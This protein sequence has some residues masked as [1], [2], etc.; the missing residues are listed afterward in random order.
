MLN[1]YPG[2]H[3]MNQTELQANVKRRNDRLVAITAKVKA[4]K[5]KVVREGDNLDGKMT[6]LENLEQNNN[7]RTQPILNP[8]P[9][10]VANVSFL[11]KIG[12]IFTSES[13]AA[14]TNLVS[15]DEKDYNAFIE[16]SKALQDILTNLSIK[17]DAIQGDDQN[18]KSETLL[19][20]VDANVDLSSA[21]LEELNPP[22]RKEYEAEILKVN[23]LLTQSLLLIFKAQRLG[24]QESLDR[25]CALKIQKIMGLKEQ[26]YKELHTTVGQEVPQEVQDSFYSLE[27]YCIQRSQNKSKHARRVVDSA[28][29]GT[30]HYEDANF[31]SYNREE[32]LD[33]ATKCVDLIVEKNTKLTK[34]DLPEAAKQGGLG[35]MMKDIYLALCEM[36]QRIFINKN[37]QFMKFQ[38]KNHESSATVSSAGLR[39]ATISSATKK[40]YLRNSRGSAYLVGNGINTVPKHYDKA[41]PV[42]WR[43]SAHYH[44]Q[45]K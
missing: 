11:S 9:P 31:G 24:N 34:N 16:T 3:T 10:I 22:S 4:V 1:N 19:G 2:W 7:T 17:V 28:E 42:N 26:I 13:G 41:P 43:G 38:G 29:Q 15:D 44:H 45:K 33:A 37:P 39:E 23:T 35:E 14:V 32:K 27:Y 18:T 8:P 30:Y 5:G 12:N 40:T 20:I 21:L 25:T 36:V 6:S